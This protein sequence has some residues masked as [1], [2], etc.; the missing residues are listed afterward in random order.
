MIDPSI[1]IGNIVEIGTII[2]GGVI[3][4]TLLR[5]TVTQLKSEVKELKIDVRA[6]NKIVIEMAVTD[7]RLLVVE[8]DIREL[9]HGRGFVKTAIEGEWPRRGLVER[10]K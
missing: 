7:R 8:E 1:T 9:R 3:T 10:E 2:I 5:S 4:F 6:L